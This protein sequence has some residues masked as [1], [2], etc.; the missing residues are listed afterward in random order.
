MVC[1]YLFGCVVGRNWRAVRCQGC[2]SLN[3]QCLLSTGWVESG[4]S[5]G[6]SA[7]TSVEGVVFRGRP[8]FIVTGFSHRSRPRPWSPDSNLDLSSHATEAP[9]STAYDLW[10]G[11]HLAGDDHI[12]H[13]CIFFLE[14][15]EPVVFFLLLENVFCGNSLGLIQCE[16]C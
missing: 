12:F 2:L 7:P 15:I 8:I 16:M 3:L 4:A 1:F 14:P 5:C 10:D 11:Y 9:P 6:R 13:G